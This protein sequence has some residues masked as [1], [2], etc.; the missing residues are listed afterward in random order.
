MAKSKFKLVVYSVLLLVLFFS[1]VS[2]LINLS[3]K[4]F[5]LEFVGVIFLLVLTLIGFSAY[6]SWGERVLFFV[7]LFYMCNLVLMWYF[8]RDLY[9]VLLII[10]LFGFLLSVPKKCVGRCKD[11]CCS[12]QEPHS[13]V[14]DPVIETKTVE[15]SVQKHVEEPVEATVKKEV[16]KTKARAKHSPGKFVASKNSNNYHEPK[17]EWAK[18]IKPARMVWFKSKEEAW[19]KGYKAHTCVKE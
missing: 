10:T 7:F 18:K 13:E 4:A 2:V 19:D 5:A 11:S 12:T 9:V 6:N 3:G 15:K 16:T 14:F 17:C 1:L 8:F